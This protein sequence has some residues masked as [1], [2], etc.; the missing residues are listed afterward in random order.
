VGRAVAL[1]E[2]ARFDFHIHPRAQIFRLA[3]AVVVLDS[4]IS[5]VNCAIEG[6]VSDHLFAAV[7]PDILTV[8]FVEGG[9]IATHR[10]L[11]LFTSQSRDRITAGD[12]SFEDNLA[13]RGREFRVRARVGSALVCATCK[14]EE[15][16]EGDDREGS[17]HGMFTAKICTNVNLP[18]GNWLASL[19]FLSSTSFPES[20][21]SAEP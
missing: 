16:Q 15:S 9:R 13:M 12:F 3:K 19:Y 11:D 17:L 8:E 18:S 21:F 2:D 7:D 14:S 5:A 6:A 4:G 20:S 10:E 1:E